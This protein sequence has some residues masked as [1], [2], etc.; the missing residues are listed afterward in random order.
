MKWRH[1]NSHLAETECQA[2][3]GFRPNFAPFPFGDPETPALQERHLELPTRRSRNQNNGSPLTKQLAI[4]A[5]GK[6]GQ[7][8]T[9]SPA[10][11]LCHLC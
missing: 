2:R 6:W 7:E 4:R 1:V 5:A 10:G 11:K 8:A 9:T 3:Y